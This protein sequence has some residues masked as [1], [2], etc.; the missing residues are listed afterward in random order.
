MIFTTYY[1]LL[2]HQL[3]I[4][5][6]C[7][8]GVQVLYKKLGAKLVVGMPFKDIATVDSIYMHE[9]PPT[10]DSEGQ[11]A[12]RRLQEV[13]VHVIAPAAALDKEPLTGK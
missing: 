6:P 10:G 13:G 7:P 12:L 3:F 11:R 9:L 2:Y 1:L 5:S 4:I 8:P